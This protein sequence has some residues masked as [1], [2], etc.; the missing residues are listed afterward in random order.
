MSSANPSPLRVLLV[1]DD[2]DDR[3]LTDDLVSQIRLPR[4]AALQWASSYEAGLAAL[5]HNGSDVCLLDY[6][7][8]GRDGLELLSEARSQGCLCPIVLLTG[9]GAEGTHSAA[10]NRG[11]DDYLSKEDL[12]VA[13]LER[14]IR[15]AIERARHVEELRASEQRYRSIFEAC[16]EGILIVDLE[17][18]AVRYANA[19]ASRK[20]GHT[21][22]ALCSMHISDLSAKGDVESDW[23]QLESLV[24]GTT[25]LAV[26]RPCLKKDGSILLADIAATTIAVGG[27]SMIAAFYRDVTERARASRAVEASEARYRRLFEAAK[28]GILILAADT[29]SIVDVNP[30][31][32]ELTGY[33]RDE[34]MGKHLWE[35]GPFK[36]ASASRDA[37]AELQA[38][39][40]VRYDD[41][42]LKTIDGRSVEVEFVS[43]V[44]LVNGSKVIQCNVRDITARKQMTA[45]LRMRERAIEAVAQGILISDPR[46]PGNPIVYASPGFTRLTGYAPDEVLGRTGRLL[47]GKDT[48]PAS[49]AVL[50]DAIREERP[51]VTELLNYRKDGT[52]FWN[53]L[54]LSPVKD[55]DGVVTN[56]VGVQ[57]DVTARRQLEA[58]F[59]QAQKMEAVGRLAGGVAHDFNNL[60]SVILSYADLISDDLKP[61]EPIRADIEQIRTAGLRATDLT[62]QL[63]AFSRQQVL[64]PRVL[65]FNE[66]V[67]GMEKMLGR[68]L[69]ADIELTILTAPA[70]GNVKA[71]PGQLEQIVMNLAVNAR[72]AMPMGGHLTLET[73]S[74]HLDADYASAHHDVQPGPYVELA[75]SDSGEGMG[76]ETMARIFEPFFTT[77][78]KA[79]GTGLGLATVFGI[80]K[81]SGGHIF[82]YS[83]PG[84]GTTFRIFLPEVGAVAEAAV[85]EPTPEAEGA[86]GT[87]LLVEDEDQVR[88]VARTILRRQG[89]VVLDASNGGEALLICEQHGAKI[90][91][92]LTDVVLPRMSGRQLAERLAPVRPSMKVLYMSGYTD[93]AILQHGII[94]SGVAFLQKPITPASLTRKVREVLRV[95]GRR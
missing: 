74:V 25:S 75:V 76:K 7:L 33:A 83:E 11:A 40:Y 12:T 84:K 4:R 63:L 86:G 14:S 3:A 65:N 38:K 95:G 42:P 56:F 60:L 52:P 85:A 18:R 35:I 2:E 41:L 78:D 82:V 15:Y 34:F 13:L 48:A 80:V 53:S 29:G 71:D 23:A 32:S 31:M 64:E 81:Q 46:R 72:D 26:D 54:S 66:V 27:R 39:D 1:D 22:D 59:R 70:L 73:A 55:N 44:Y 58:Q 43:N 37:F 45:E 92:L 91:L 89:Y 90:D 94:D 69:G 5:R 36:D 49:I 21:A 16:S 28:D 6:R 17:T 93:D 87:I 61:D 57:T 51:C 9:K 62:R 77:K 68:L 88:T 47:Q 79:K 50:R 19:A 8:G 20:F 30:F 10:M 24:R 67:G